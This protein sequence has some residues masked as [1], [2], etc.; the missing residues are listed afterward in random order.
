MR[1]DD[2][3]KEI[4][5]LAIALKERIEADVD[6][7][8]LDPIARKERIAA[9]NDPVTGYEFFV[10]N[11]F[12][13]YIRHP[14]KSRL[15]ASLFKLLPEMVNSE[16]PQ[17]LA[18]AAP[19]GEAKSTMVTQLFSLWS[20]ITN[21]KKFIVIV[22]DSI[23]Q[24]YP[25][26]EA[27]KAELE[28]NPRLKS[29]FPDEFG[30]G[31]VWQ[32]GT[33]V[34]AKGTK[35]QVAG[36]GKRLRGLRHGAYR[37]DLVIG[38]DLENDENVSSPEQRDKL[39]SWF[40][41][42]LMPLGEV[43]GKI[44][45]VIIGTILHYDSLLNRLLSNPFW[46]SYRFKSLIEWPN[47][48]SLWDKWEEIY[49][50]DGEAPAKAFYEANYD[51]MNDGAVLSWPARTLLSLMIIRARD[52]HDTFDSEQQND[53]VSSE[54]ALF[55][56][57]IHYWNDLPDGLVYF[58]SCDP[59]LGKSG[60]RSDPSAILAGGYDRETGKLYVIDAEI[61]KRLPDRIIMDVID[62]QKRRRQIIAWSFETVQFQEFLMTELVKAAAKQHIHVP[63]VP[64]KP[65]TDK[66]LRIESLQ[67]HMKNGFILLHPSQTTLITQLKHFPM[68]DHDDGPDALHM[69]WEIARKRSQIYEFESI[70]SNY[71]IDSDDDNAWFGR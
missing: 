34:T 40:N 20:V 45:F 62:M 23:D 55:N 7:F 37:P 31:R 60:R 19:R 4:E 59:S 50:N 33:I 61:K 32:V 21:R 10:N 16:E 36:S 29:D 8:D 48:M 22:M 14:S 49:R 15:H 35:I 11:Y 56:D 66:M 18:L 70:G 26:L 41:K 43:G 24:A 71:S 64:I 39:H 27:I 38:D 46:K 52:G 5:E 68:A 25:M 28:F 67:P 65:T 30:K 58:A 57:A 44:D 51:E 1:K 3:I 13:H 63:A 47:N 12:P 53:P 54:H 2:F 9:V 6:G 17:H 42:T 69:L